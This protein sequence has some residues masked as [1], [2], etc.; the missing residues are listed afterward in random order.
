M[1]QNAAGHQALN[2]CLGPGWFK[3]FNGGLADGPSYHPKL[4]WGGGL[5]YN[6]ALTAA[7]EVKVGVRY[8]QSVI[9]E[10][11]GGEFYWP[12]EISTGV[13]IYDPTLPHS[14]TKKLHVQTWQYL[15][16]TRLYLGPLKTWR[17]YA[18]LECGLSRSKQDQAPELSAPDLT[19]GLGIGL[20]W[21]PAGKRFGMFL[22]PALRYVISGHFDS[23]AVAAV[24]VGLRTQL[25]TGK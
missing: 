20:Q 25:F 13:Y 8:H 9:V 11:S 6:Y 12:S 3:Q 16:G 1:A 5:D 14:F 22:Q 18:N 4:G 21:L 15:L 7:L 24:E 10:E 17:W 19:G 23:Y 2:I